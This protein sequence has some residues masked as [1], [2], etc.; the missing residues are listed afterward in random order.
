MRP[1]LIGIAG[2]TGSGKTTVAVK[3]AEALPAERAALIQQDWYYRDRSHL[4]PAARA[5]INFDE[6]DALEND[7][8]LADLLALKAGRPVD[9]PQYDFSSHTRRAERRTILP[10]S[11]IL[12]E[13]IL[14][15]AV[16]P[17]RDALDL[18]LFVDTDD[19]VRLLRRV[20][21]D[22][23]ER[24]RDI[25][26]IE[27]QYLASVRRMHQQHV[28]PSRAHA[29]LIIPEGGQNAPALEVIVGRLRYLL[30]G[31]GP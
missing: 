20:R 11:I 8:L 9:C 18:R 27:S 3:L 25:Q 31:G 13:G 7:L 4:D 1:T 29:H 14:L 19:D 21:R 17:L 22:I 5:L 16:A 15:F 28:A 10:R 6:P 2:G 26:S 24:G 30:D 12:V 23:E